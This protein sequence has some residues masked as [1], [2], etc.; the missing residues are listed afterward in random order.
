M[1]LGYGLA[2]V[3]I[4]GWFLPIGI[5]ILIAIVIGVCVVSLELRFGR[6]ARSKRDQQRGQLDDSA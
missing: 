6:S 5:T 1:G 3:L 4:F 2:A